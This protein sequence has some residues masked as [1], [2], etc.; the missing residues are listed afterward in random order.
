MSN[1]TDSQ[2]FNETIYFEEKI[3]SEK[4]AFLLSLND[5]DLLNIIYDKDEIA[6]DGKKVDKEDYIKTTKRFLTRMK[7]HHFKQKRTY[8]FGKSVNKGRQYVKD[9]MGVQGLQSDLRAFLTVDEYNDYDMVNAHPTI[10]NYLV[11]KYFPDDPFPFLEKYINEREEIIKEDRKKLKNTII[12]GMNSNKYLKHKNKFINSLDHEFKTIQ[13]LFLE[14]NHF[15]EIC[16]KTG[17]TTK[18]KEGS[19]LNKVLCI[20]ENKILMECA[21]LIGYDNIGCLIFD[22][23]L[24][25]KKRDIGEVLKILN[26]YCVKE[27]KIKWLNKP[28]DSNIEIPDDWT[29][30]PILSEFEIEYLLS[31]ENLSSIFLDKFGLCKDDLEESNLVYKD[32]ILYIFLKDKWFIDDKLERLENCIS[33]I[34]I[35]YVTE[36]HKFYND[37]SDEDNVKIYTSMLKTINKSNKIT[38]IRKTVI[39]KLSVLNFE[40]IEFDCNPDLFVFNNIAYDLKTHTTRKLVKKD[41]VLTR[42]DYNLEERDEEKIK[43]VTKIIKNILIDDDIRNNMIQIIST[44]LYGRKIINFTIANGD[45]SNGK[46]TLFDLVRHLLVKGIYCY[47]ASPSILNQ[48]ISNKNNP[49]IASIHNKRLVIMSEASSEKKLNIAIIKKFTG[50]NQLGARMNHSN[51]MI[52]NNTATFVLQANEVPKLDGNADDNATKRRITDIPFKSTFTTDKSILEE[53]KDDKY[54]IEAI[55]YYTEEEFLKENRCSFFYY[56]ID[57]IKAFE[58]KN[59]YKVYEKVELCDEVK[60]RSE[61]YIKSSNEINN[62]FSER[63]EKTE[64]END[65]IK[66]KDLYQEITLSEFYKNYSREE[67]RAFTITHFTNYIKKSMTFK[68]YY[69]NRKKIKGKDIRNVITNFKQSRIADEDEEQ[70]FE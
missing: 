12:I 11:K 2:S 69:Y 13:K 46:S 33:D 19:Y 28:L 37:K 44:C 3:D 59:K 48:D 14:C 60:K 68:K 43:I 9:G 8:K 27:Y 7:K 16:T 5:T 41:K 26:D 50:E 52:V 32:S 66:V 20:Y 29:A 4:V 51:S 58:K 10:L 63:Y 35:K 15:N 22:G 47:V 42:L 25:D 38:S 31:D 18:N 67:K 30:P 34:L 64:N 24:V 36:K 54:M 21:K 45:G 61:N 39:N 49:E 62:Y 53:N 23:F 56:L 55:P 17:L 6:K 40:K 70:D 57:Y 1:S 65:Y